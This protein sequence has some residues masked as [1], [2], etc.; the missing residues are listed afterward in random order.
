MPLINSSSDKARQEN[1]KTEIR[2][3]RPIKQA[4][5]IGYAK[6]RESSH[7]DRHNERVLHERRKYGK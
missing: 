5:A 6:Q 4:V 2:A 3:G 7:D 1:I